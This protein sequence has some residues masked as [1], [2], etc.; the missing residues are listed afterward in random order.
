MNAKYSRQLEVYEKQNRGEHLTG[1]ERR[2]K[3]K[4]NA[5]RV[6]SVKV[7]DGVK[8]TRYKPNI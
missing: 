6:Q 3:K 8:V 4:Y 7:V 1:Q 5:D 2:W